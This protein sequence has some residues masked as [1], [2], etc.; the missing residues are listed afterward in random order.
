MVTYTPN[1]PEKWLVSYTDN[2]RFLWLSSVFMPIFPMLGINTAHEMGHKKTALERWLAKIVLFHLERH[3]DQHANPTRRCQSLRNFDNLPE[4]P[5]GYYGMYL[6]A[7][8]PWL[9]YRVMD[10]RVLSLPHINGD[11]GKVN[12][13]PDKR[14]K[15]YARFGGGHT[16]TAVAA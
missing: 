7:Y 15:I 13:D 1:H 9:W 3:S 5:N 12:I 8:L 10:R 4:L 14:D 6:I 2:K 11:L 16:P